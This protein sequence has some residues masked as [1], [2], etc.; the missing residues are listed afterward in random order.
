MD[1]Q[2]RALMLKICEGDMR[3]PP[4]L[5]MVKDN[6]RRIEFMSYLVQ[7]G[8]VGGQFILWLQNHYGGSIVAAVTDVCSSSTILYL[9]R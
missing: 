6:P 4:Y 5:F 3:V 8:L 7:K 2:T 9:R 1:S